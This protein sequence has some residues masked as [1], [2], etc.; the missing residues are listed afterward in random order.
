VNQE[1]LSPNHGNAVSRS[2]E[3]IRIQAGGRV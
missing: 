3:A 1:T 2:P